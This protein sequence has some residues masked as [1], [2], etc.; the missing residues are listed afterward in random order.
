M[1]D[2]GHFSDL[3]EVLERD[4]LAIDRTGGILGQ[5]RLPGR[6]FL[7]RGLG[8]RDAVPPGL[9]QPE[10]GQHLSHCLHSLRRCPGR[11]CDVRE[12]EWTPPSRRP[13]RLRGSDR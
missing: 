8:Q 2:L 6:S 11:I 3:V 9:L 12:R 7:P 5:D 10:Y 1:V 13:K 4:A